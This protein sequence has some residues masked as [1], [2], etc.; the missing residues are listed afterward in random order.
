MNCGVGR[1]RGLDPVLLW[2]WRRPVSTALIQ[3]LAWE[4]P[5]AV[6]AAITKKRKKKK[7]KKRRKKKRKEIRGGYYTC[8]PLSLLAGYSS[9]QSD[10]T[11][12]FRGCLRETSIKY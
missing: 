10:T 6:S 8:Q 9:E 11:T 3:P 12:A 4:L 2:L 7:K 1:R 5:Y